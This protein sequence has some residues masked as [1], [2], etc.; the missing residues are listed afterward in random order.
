MYLILNS[1]SKI[2]QQIWKE[3]WVLL[4]TFVDKSFTEMN[5]EKFINRI[6]FSSFL[7]LCLNINFDCK[8]LF[9]MK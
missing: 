3:K 5:S 2:Q 6:Y 7:V 8:A 1:Q 4:N 9:S